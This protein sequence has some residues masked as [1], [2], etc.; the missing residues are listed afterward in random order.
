[1]RKVLVLSL[2][3]LLLPY[4]LLFASSTFVVRNQADFCRITEHVLQLKNEGVRRVKVEIMPGTYEFNEGCFSLKD[5]IAPNLSLRIIGK[6]EVR[7][8]PVGKSYKNK[9]VYEGPFNMDNSWISGN[10]DL[11]I[12]GKTRY[13]QGLIEVVD[14]NN[15]ICR[16]KS[17][18]ILPN[19]LDASNVFVLIPEWYTTKAYKVIRIEKEYVYFVASD[20]TNSFYNGLNVNDDYNYAKKELRFRLCNVENDKDVISVIKQKVSLPNDYSSIREGRVQNFV[21]IYNC[22]FKNIEFSNLKFIGNGARNNTALFYFNNTRSKQIIVKR[23]EFL[24]MRSGVILIKG[25]SNVFIKGNIFKDCY[26]YGVYSDNA[27]INTHIEDNQFSVMGKRFQNSFCISCS[28][29]DF[30]ISNNILKDFGYG[31]VSLGMWY[32]SEQ[33]N[34]CRGIVENNEFFYSDSFLKEVPESGLM[35]GGAIYTYSKND[36][37][38]IRY[39]YIHDISGVADNRGIFCDDGA[40]GL[41]ICGNVITKIY[42]SYCIDSRRVSSIENYAQGSNVK[43]ANIN[44]EITNNIVD[45]DVRFEANEVVNNGCKYGGNYILTAKKTRMPVI[46]I[47]DVDNKES[48]IYLDCI[49]FHKGKLE[50]AKESYKILKRSPIWPGIKKHINK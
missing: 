47:K 43:N 34:S 33:K 50:V 23:C 3:L 45:G 41:L 9:D 26:Y 25:T 4:R 29:S 17:K 42:N 24:G 19:I 38:I 39:N 1:M 36:G 31:G 18:E 37:T 46:T 5:I 15:K 22:I 11:N 28:G 44:V 21:T 35:D 30:Y 40:Y 8:I 27:S 14:V 10:K 12:W 20:L 13:V 7:I 6:G 16:L 49:G 32:G 48:D 2:I